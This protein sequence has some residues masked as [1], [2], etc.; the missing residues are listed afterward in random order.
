MKEAGSLQEAEVEAE[1]EGATEEETEEISEQL[2]QEETVVMAGDEVDEDQEVT[3]EGN[4][5]HY[6]DEDG[7]VVTM[8]SASS[9]DVQYLQDDGTLMSAQSTVIINPDA[10]IV[11]ENSD[12]QNEAEY[13]LGDQTPEIMQ[14]DTGEGIQLVRAAGDGTYEVI[15]EEEAALILQNQEQAVE[16]FD[17]SP[18]NQVPFFFLC[19]P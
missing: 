17:N 11:T 2:N 8:D 1:T 13:V 7:S 12:E 14:M 19:G 16:V 15:S 5:I 18:E 6:I 4:V 3:V 9:S 10:S